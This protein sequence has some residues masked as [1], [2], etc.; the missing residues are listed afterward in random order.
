[1][2]CGLQQ[3]QHWQKWR[4]NLKR[5]RS[6]LLL[7]ETNLYK[8]FLLLAAPVF[9]SNFLKSFHDLVD[10][11]FI[12]QMPNSVSAQAAI[13]IT[14][15]L[16]NILLSLN[17]GLAIAGVSII[18]RNIGAGKKELA[19]QYS[20]ML[21][22]LAFMFGLVLGILQFFCAPLIMQWMGAEGE[23]LSL[24]V[25]YLRVRSFEMVFI[26]IFA[27]FQAMRQATGDTTTPVVISTISVVVNIILT[28]VFVQ[29]FHMGVFGA[30]FA[31]LIGQACMMPFC[32]YLTFHRNNLIYITKKHLKI[33]VEYFKNLF[34]VALPAATGQAASSL[35]FLVLQA[36]ILDY[37]EV[38]AAA[39]SNGNKISNLL[40]MPVMSIGSVLAAY[41]GQNI[42]AKNPKRA[43]AAY[44]TGRNLSLFI[45]VVGCAILLPLREPIIKL[46]TNHPETQIVAV[47]YAFFVVLTQ[48]LM[49]LFQNYL[50]V[51]NGSG[52]T[53]YAFIISMMRLWAIRLPL[54]L[55]FKN[56]TDFGRL[57][58]WYAMVI[59]NLIIIIPGWYLFKRLD[60]GGEKET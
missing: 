36:L 22:V 40:L 43:M 16:I 8:A 52:K 41:V 44:K 34:Q 46:L 54:I 55:L 57:G 28:G 14:W 29:I 5:D 3:K 38:V 59:S 58:I 26:F 19:R 9:L 17:A 23:I 50:G 47:E 53:K 2:H 4:I 60:F 51:F 6:Q 30:A 27:S 21:Y 15:P 35:G 33:D 25:L 48:P 39:F 12:G 10:T 31:T 18:S 56:F 49:A 11:Y 7:Q 32:L 37:G 13:S 45:S 24:A 42:G 1:M 20:G